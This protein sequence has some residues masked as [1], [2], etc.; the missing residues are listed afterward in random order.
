[1]AQLFKENILLKDFTTYKIGG[2]AKYFFIAKIKEDII[3]A[4]KFAKQNKLPIFIFGGFSNVLISEKGLEGLAIKIQNSEL[5]ILY[6]NQIYVGAGVPLSKLAGFAKQNSLSGLEWAFGI[7]QATIGGAVFGNAQ[8]FGNRISNAVKQVEVLDLKNFKIKIFSKE[9]CEFSLKNS[10][11]KKNRNLI[12]LSVIIQLEKKNI[13][14]IKEKTKKFLDYRKQC[15]PMN[16]PSAGSVF[17][18]PERKIINKKLLKNFPELAEYN[19]KGV[20][21]AG[22]LISKCQLA[23]KKIGEAQISEKHANFIVNLGGA[24]AK[25]VLALIQLAQ[26]KVKERF[27]IKLNTEVQFIGFDKT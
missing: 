27:G 6:P 3:K 4:L 8:A 2:P 16:F 17:V 7:P 11:F 9:Q 23:G 10:I 25:D 21:P 19:Q 13:E 12:I 1:V 18:N 26:K 24:K 5:K 15:H 22:Y 14:Q 20:I